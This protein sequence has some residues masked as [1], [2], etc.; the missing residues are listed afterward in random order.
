MRMKPVKRIYLIIRLCLQLARNILPGVICRISRRKI[1]FAPEKDKP[2]ILIISFIEWQGAFQRPQ[3]LARELSALGY[4]VVYLSLL[5]LHRALKFPPWADFSR[6]K[7]VSP[8]LLITTPLAFP[9]DLRFSLFRELNN[10]ILLSTIK[11]LRHKIGTPY[12]IVNA[13]FFNSA[14]FNLEY[15]GLL[16]DIMDEFTIGGGAEINL[17]EEELINRANFV[18]SG[19]AA[20]AELK[21]KLRPDIKFISCGVDYEHFAQIE[22]SATTPPKDIVQ[23][24][25]PIVGYFGAINERIDFHLV[26]ELAENLPEVNFLFIGPI[27]AKLPPLL[28]KK[29]LVFLG[30]RPY[31]SLPAYLSA[32]DIAIVPYRLSGG[33]EF[34]NPVKVLE[35]LA[36]G[37]PV[38][39]TDIA[40]VRRFY[41]ETVFIARDAKD[42]ITKIRLIITNPELKKEKIDKGKKLARQRTWRVMTEEFLSLLRIQESEFRIKNRAHTSEFL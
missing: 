19:T 15:R 13:P 33:V 8:N 37:K 5:R 27:S 7:E 16:Y 26:S 17:A 6:C 28:R 9:L 18:S 14:V 29:N 36:G 34:A 35:Y 3:H 42:F 2:S 38:V 23:K 41:S 25:H 39:S 32:F 20:V 24:P 11:H 1:T 31:E 12:V 30:W 40:D 4:K 22:D 10:A 21:S